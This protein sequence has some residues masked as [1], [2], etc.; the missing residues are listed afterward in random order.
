MEC[1]E[2]APGTLT[3]EE[4]EKGRYVECASLSGLQVDIFSD[5]IG[6]EIRLAYLCEN[7]RRTPVTGITFSARLGEVLKEARIASE[8]VTSGPYEG[9]AFMLLKDVSIL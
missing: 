2:V 5:Y 3:K 8:T 1:V 4:L 7:G 9:P 6:G